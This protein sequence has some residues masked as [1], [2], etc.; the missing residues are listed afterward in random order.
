MAEWNIGFGVVIDCTSSFK[1]ESR[2]SHTHTHTHTHR[3]THTHTQTH[4]H[5]HIKTHTHTH[6]QKH[7]HT[8]THNAVQFKILLTTA[9]ISSTGR[10]YTT[11]RP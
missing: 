3:H 4:T 10:T 1:E 11:L 6:T 9:A 8:H 7:T 5:T 2:R